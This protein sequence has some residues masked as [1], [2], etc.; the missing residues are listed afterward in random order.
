MPLS[1]SSKGSQSDPKLVHLN[2]CSM[3]RTGV[4]WVNLWKTGVMVLV[5][6]FYCSLWRGEEVFMWSPEHGELVNYFRIMTLTLGQWRSRHSEPHGDYTNYD[7]LSDLNPSRS[8]FPQLEAP[9][10]S[11]WILS[12]FSFALLLSLY[13]QPSNQHA[14]VNGLI[15][16]GRWYLKFLN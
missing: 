12:R 11:V 4:M 13:Y 3:V 5:W 10:M 8:Y 2:G 16:T 7:K 15:N 6:T 14:L 9:A 1:Q